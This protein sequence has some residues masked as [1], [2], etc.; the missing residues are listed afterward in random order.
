[1][2]LKKI[3][4]YCECGSLKSCCPQCG[5]V[6]SWHFT[7]GEPASSIEDRFDK[8]SPDEGECWKCG[9]TYSE[10]VKHTL[11]EQLEKFREEKITKKMVKE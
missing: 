3:L 11:Y 9:F 6:K 10:H 8:V 4:N 7:E 5:S 2:T 1:M